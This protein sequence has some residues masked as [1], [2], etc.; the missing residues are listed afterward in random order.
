MNENNELLETKKELQR[1]YK[2]LKIVGEYNKKLLDQNQ[3]LEKA[4]GEGQTVKAQ[5]LL[6]NIQ[7]ETLKHHSKE[8]ETINKEKQILESNIKKLEEEKVKN[9]KEMDIVMKE[10]FTLRDENKRQ[11]EFINKKIITEKEASTPRDKTLRGHDNDLVREENNALK[12]EIESLKKVV[13]DFE[14]T[15]YWWLEGG[16]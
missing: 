11:K 10:V 6:L 4:I 1:L 16:Y 15:D 14:V 5:K 3:K 8:V 9:K 2:D 12:A 13:T 7:K